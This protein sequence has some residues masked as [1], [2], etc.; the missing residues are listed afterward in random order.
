[1]FLVQEN[2]KIGAFIKLTSFLKKCNVGYQPT[3]SKILTRAEVNRFI[4]KGSP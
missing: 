3:Q 2:V 4:F 1:M